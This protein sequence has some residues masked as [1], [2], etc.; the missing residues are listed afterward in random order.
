LELYNKALD[1]DK[2]N[3]N[4]LNNKD[5]CYDRI[6]KYDEAIKWYDKALEV[7]PNYVNALNVK[8]FCFYNLTRY[9]EAIE[10]FDRA[11]E[12]DPKN[13]FAKEYKRRIEDYSRQPI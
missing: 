11:I 9:N 4:T 12:V 13:S 3:V 2:N 6:G 1:L 7:D 5:L 8:G 10:C